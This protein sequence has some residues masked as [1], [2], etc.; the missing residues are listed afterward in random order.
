MISQE[1]IEAVKKQKADI[2]YIHYQKNDLLCDFTRVFTLD[3]VTFNGKNHATLRLDIVN[4][5][6]YDPVKIKFD[7]LTVAYAEDK[8]GD[9][10]VSIVFKSPKDQYVKKIGASMAGVALS[11]YLDGDSVSF[12]HVFR[13]FEYISFVLTIPFESVVDADNSILPFGYLQKLGISGLRNAVVMSKVKEEIESFMFR[14]IDN[15]SGSS[16]SAYELVAN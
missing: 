7:A 3:G 15:F 4:D 8:N 2:K 5:F 11:K 12:P 6:D 10:A 9:L 14:H 16:I 13:P 1:Q